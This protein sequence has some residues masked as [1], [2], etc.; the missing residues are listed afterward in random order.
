M[1]AEL[2]GPA[3]VIASVMK[4]AQRTE[5]VQFLDQ[6]WGVRKNGC[7][8]ILWEPHEKQDCIQFFLRL[9]RLDEEEKILMVMPHINGAGIAEQAAAACDMN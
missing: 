3:R 9:T 8:L 2:K 6:S 1:L 7:L 4:E 5:I